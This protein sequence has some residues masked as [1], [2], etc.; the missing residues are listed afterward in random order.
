MVEGTRACRRR[1][2]YALLPNLRRSLFFAIR[3][4]SIMFVICFVHTSAP[5][6]DTPGQRPPHI[7]CHCVNTVTLGWVGVPNECTPFGI[8]DV[9]VGFVDRCLSRTPK[10]AARTKHPPEFIYIYVYI[11]LSRVN[12]GPRKKKRG[13]LES[14]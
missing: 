11:L 14:L 6:Y 4:G 7:K 5:F 9:L 8:H 3:D 13:F 2:M 1:P 10:L 12:I